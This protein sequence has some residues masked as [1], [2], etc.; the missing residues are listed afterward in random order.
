M[1]SL[2]LSGSPGY[3]AEPSNTQIVRS[4][5]AELTVLEAA[6]FISTRFSPIGRRE[7]LGIG[8]KPLE[9]LLAVDFEANLARLART[10]LREIRPPYQCRGRHRHHDSERQANAKMS[11]RLL[12]HELKRSELAL[13]ESSQG[14]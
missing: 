9:H 4:R 6:T 1:N 5:V 8:D 10:E 7:G 11:F 2:L 3:C 13:R 14:R 12:V